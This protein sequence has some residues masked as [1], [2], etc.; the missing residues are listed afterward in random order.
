MQSLDPDLRHTPLSYY[1]PDGPLGEVMQ[2]VMA[3]PDPVRRWAVGLGAGSLACY[4]DRAGSPWTFVEID[5]VVIRI[6]RDSGHF[7]FLSDCGPDARILEGDGRLRLAEA[8]DGGLDLLVMD[9]FTSDA[10]PLHLMTL[11]A[12]EL[13]RSKMADGGV[14]LVHIS[15]RA[16]NLRPVVGNVAA[17]AGLQ[18]SVRLDAGDPEVP[19]RTASEWIVLARDAQTIDDLG[20]AP[21]WT[22]LEASPDHRP[23]TDDYADILPY[24]HWEVW[25]LASL[26]RLLGRDDDDEG[27]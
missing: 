24:L 8:P 19:F 22:K 20:L 4:G 7:G 25:R 21:E 13:Y 23:W 16:I 11:E 18:A 1:H 15:N 9:A 3:R 12:F 14:I 5:P 27:Q 2:K 10:I 26:D 6:A 17:L